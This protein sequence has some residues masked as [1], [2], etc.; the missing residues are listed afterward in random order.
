LPQSRSQVIESLYQAGFIDHDVETGWSILNVG[1]LLL[2]SDIN[3]FPTVSRKALRIVRYSGLSKVDAAREYVTHNGYAVG[4]DTM[5]GR[6]MD[7]LP[8]NE[9]I[10]GALRTTQAYP[11]FVIRELIANALIHQDLSLTG[12]SPMVEVF[13]N[14]VEISNPGLPIVSIERFIDSFQQSRNERV[15]RAMR[16]LG[17]CEERGT[18]WDKVTS[19]I[20]LHQLPPPLVE[21]AVIGTRVVVYGPRPLDK[22]EKAD[23]IRAVYQHACLK[24]VSGDIMTNATVRRRF[25]IDEENNA[26]ASRLIREAVQAGVIVPFD[27]SAGPTA[28]RYIPAWA[29]ADRRP[30]P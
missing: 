17:I 11:V 14:R 18:G 4:F 6:V 22:M 19:E 7:L 26:T 29:A 3:R 15:A 16:L 23:R 12:V 24:Y 9:I 30:N 28:I 8:E 5:V 10:N 25:G 27:S 2:A 21:T 20:E 13:D 1:A